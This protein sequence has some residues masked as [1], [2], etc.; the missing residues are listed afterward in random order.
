MRDLPNPSRLEIRIDEWQVARG[1]TDA[2]DVVVDW[3]GVRD[4]PALAELLKALPPRA[5]LV[6]MRLLDGRT[7]LVPKAWKSLRF[8]S[9]PPIFEA[10]RRDYEAWVQGLRWANVPSVDR[11]PKYLIEMI[12]RQVPDFDGF[13]EEEQI[14]FVVR[15]QEKIEKIRASVEGL[16]LHLEYATPG[17]HKAFPPLEDPLR[18]I[19]AAVFTDVMS[20]RRAGELLRVPVP[21]T[22]K[23]RHENQ[24]VRKMANRGRQLLLISFGRAGWA[25]RVER[26]RENRRWWERWESLDDPK[27]QIYALLAKARGTSAEHERASSKDDGFDH[28]LDEWIAVSEQ[29]LNTE[30][31]LGKGNSS[32]EQDDVRRAARRLLD[33][34]V[35]IEERDERFKQALSLLDAPPAN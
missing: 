1:D 8:G 17:K 4:D 3:R 23:D 6:P 13:A 14:D 7:E 33:E 31:I 11:A 22:D 26:M 34:Q 20:S 29:R 21:E 24:T 9:G 25:I 28:L 2:I 32:A 27:E 12:R 16:I 15:T 18:D 30:E 35:S 19:K 10:A 5:A